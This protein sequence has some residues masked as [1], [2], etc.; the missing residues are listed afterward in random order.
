MLISV[1]V[2][3]PW[4]AIPVFGFQIAAAWKLG[5]TLQLSASAFRWCMVGLFLPI[6][7]FFATMYLHRRAVA[8]M[9]QAGIKVGLFGG[10]LPAG[11]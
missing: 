5:K 7:A 10:R 3:L 8:L 1:G 11:A 2:L 6:A 4:A 9:K